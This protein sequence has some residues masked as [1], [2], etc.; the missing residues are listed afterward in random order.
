[1]LAHR[2]QE[3]LSRNEQIPKLGAYEVGDLVYCANERTTRTGTLRG[4]VR[5]FTGPFE[6]TERVNKTTYAIQPADGRRP[7]RARRENVHVGRLAM[8]RDAC[9]HHRSSGEQQRSSWR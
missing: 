9:R 7:S 5:P 3:R 8:D 4:H 2:T 6:I 1:M